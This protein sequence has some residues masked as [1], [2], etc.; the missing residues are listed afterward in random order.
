MA[1]L[2][3]VRAAKAVHTAALMDRPNVVGVGIGRRIVGNVQTDQLCLS[4]LVADKI[5]VEGLAAEAL[6][7]SQLG[8]VPTDVV[9]VGVLRAHQ[10]PTG[11][12]RP[13]PGGVSIGHYQISAG[14]LGCIVRD[15]TTGTRLILSNNH[16]LANSNDAVIGDP[17]L[18]PG[19]ADGGSVANDHIANLE[20]FCT[21]DFGTTGGSDCGIASA[22]AGFGNALASLL[23]SRHR[24]SVLQT[25]PQAVN[26]VDAA[27]ARPLNDNDVLDEILNIGQITG[28]TEGALGMAVRKMGRTTGYTTDVITTIEATVSVSYGLGK[29]ATFEN[30]FIAGPMSAGGDSGSL[31]VATN[32]Q[33]AVGLLFAGSTQT[34]IFNPI[35]AVLDCLNVEI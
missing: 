32:S 18:Q 10:D 7:P 25:N 27:V 12:F 29:V 6:V 31:I 15:R 17:I 13:A 26:L 28:T 34:T 23:G 33:E 8:D 1:T 2:A 3:E 35:Q 9:Q 22:Y 21:I 4:V 11:R 16:V 24:V 14:T 5:A 19:G 20:R 30:Q